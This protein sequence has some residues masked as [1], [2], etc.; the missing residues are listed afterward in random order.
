MDHELDQPASDGPTQPGDVAESES[1]RRGSKGVVSKLAKAAS[2]WYGITP[3]TDEPQQQDD[4]PEVQPRKVASGAV[5]REQKKRAQAEPSLGRKRSVRGSGIRDRRR[6]YDEDEEDEASGSGSSDSVSSTFPSR[7]AAMPY[8]RDTCEA[9]PKD[10]LIYL[11]LLRIRLRLFVDEALA[12][13][14]R[15]QPHLAPSNVGRTTATRPDP[16]NTSTCI[17]QDG[18]SLTERSH[19]SC[20]GK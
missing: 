12:S 17:S 1:P 18:Q 7:H 2:S 9:G 8:A 13:R 16:H 20:S 3:T 10:S 15:S 5:K 14:A 6:R 19:T 11:T 4:E